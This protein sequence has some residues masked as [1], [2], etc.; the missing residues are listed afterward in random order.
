[1]K[2][3]M[4]H[5]RVRRRAAFT[6]IEMMVALA[7]LGG[8]MS[9]VTMIMVRM[10]D[11]VT[12][13]QAI[14]RANARIK[15]ISHVMHNDFRR[16]TRG[17]V[18]ALTTNGTGPALVL[19]TGE[20]TDSIKTIAQGRGSVIVY[21]LQPN[22][23][24]DG[25]EVFWRPERIF[26]IEVGTTGPDVEGGYSLE[27]IQGFNESA[28][29]T[30]AMA[31]AASLNDS[32]YMPPANLSEVDSLWQIL[33]E[34]ASDLSF[35]WTDGT[36]SESGEMNWYDSS[37]DGIGPIWYGGNTA[38]WPK[39]IRISFTL[40]LDDPQLPEGMRVQTVEVICDVLQ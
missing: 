37:I 13:S 26:P 28:A 15:A 30:F 38:A 5:S 18:L 11:L 39:A 12:T 27:E 33:T 23:A 35:K 14:S 2:K 21:A 3:R 8:L 6:V 36:V 9:A 29:N 17:G 31:M 34:G 20:P 10:R 16:L 7:V 1:M 4:I 25:G 40:T 32:L 22:D 24:R 19:V